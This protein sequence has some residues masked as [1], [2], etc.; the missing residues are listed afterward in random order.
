MIS[1]TTGGGRILAGAQLLFLN[2]SNFFFLL[3]IFT[4][5]VTVRFAVT[6]GIGKRDLALLSC[7]Y[8]MPFFLLKLS[9][10]FLGT[11][12]LKHGLDREKKSSYNLLVSAS[13]GDSSCYTNLT[14]DILDVNDC[15]PKFTKPRYIKL[16]AVD[17]K[18]NAF[19]LRVEAI[20]KDVGVNRKIRYAFAN[21]STANL[22]TIEKETGVILLKHRLLR[23]DEEKFVFNVIATDGG[24]PSL[25][26]I[27]SV[28]II[29]STIENCPFVQDVYKEDISEHVK[30]PFEVDTV[31]VTCSNSKDFTIVYR[32]LSEL[33]KIH[34]LFKIDEATGKI[35]L[36]SALDY[37]TTR[38]HIFTVE[39]LMKKPSGKSILI[40][41]ASVKVKVLDYNDNK[42]VFSRRSYEA[43]VKEGSDNGT[44][45]IPLSASDNDTSSQLY[46]TIIKSTPND[47]P[48]VVDASNGIVSVQGELDYERVRKYE[49]VVRVQDDGNPPL[50]SDVNL[51]IN[52]KDLNDNPP[53]V[54]KQIKMLLRTDTRSGSI[55]F[56]L[57]PTDKDGPTNSK[58][59]RFSIISGGNNAFRLNSSSGALLVRGALTQ[60]NIT[61]HM[62]LQ[63]VDSGSPALSAQ[64]LVEIT[65]VKPT[66][67]PPDVQPITAYVNMRTGKFTGGIVGKIIA[68]NIA[69]GTILQFTL[70]KGNPAFSIG[71]ED[72][73]I[74]MLSELDSGSYPLQIQVT[75]GTYK[76]NSQVIVHVKE[77]T[78]DV[79]NNSVTVRITG[80]TLGSFV[81]TSLSAMINTLANIKSCAVEDVYLWSIQSSPKNMMDIVFAVKRK[82]KEVR[83]FAIR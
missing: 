62:T 42:P 49:L 33:D 10:S 69:K 53:V 56:Q 55:V 67:N 66:V 22:F 81:S 75:D 82:G 13:D 68:N 28:E 50:F 60:P 29:V 4:I 1:S 57:K 41:S 26:S 15:A 70:L 35:T 76:V 21:S 3:Q 64:T 40:S 25:S 63:T 27:A 61:Y 32:I 9:F 2:S 52:V 54:E 80:K 43:T 79:V 16:I 46:F 48:F 23:R 38:A 83:I 18:E 65:L 17:A 45:V 71:S 51:V 34:E 59:F 74:R 11:V 12:I 47:C 7:Q 36:S 5:L 31:S 8:P 20:D 37:E 39:A 73:S 78:P 30:P 19:L 6:M 44:I 24:V 77:I 58:P 72:G 14:I